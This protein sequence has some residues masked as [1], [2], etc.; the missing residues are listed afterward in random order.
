MQ[1]YAAVSSNSNWRC[2]RNLLLPRPQA[3]SAQ[4]HLP[5]KKSQ[6][7]R[8]PLRQDFTD[9]FWQNH[10]FW[11]F[12]I[13]LQFKGYNFFCIFFEKRPFCPKIEQTT[14]WIGLNFHKIGGRKNN[15]GPCFNNIKA[16]FNNLWPCFCHFWAKKREKPP[17]SSLVVQSYNK[18]SWN[19]NREKSVN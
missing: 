14:R 5:T 12:N 16:C 1:P 4:R 8:R 17:G 11:E 19:P 15:I 7:N 3:E 9:L 18:I 10:A 13:Y 6:A 2:S